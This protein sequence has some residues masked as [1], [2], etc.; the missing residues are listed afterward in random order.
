MPS[1]DPYR[2]PPWTFLYKLKLL[3]IWTAYHRSFKQLRINWMWTWKWCIGRK[4]SKTIIYREDFVRYCEI[5]G[6]KWVS[7]QN[8]EIWQVYDCCVIV[9][10]CDWS[11]TQIFHVFCI[12]F[13]FIYGNFNVLSFPL[14]IYYSFE[15]FLILV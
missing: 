7:R 4:L 6:K 13:K 15:S 1:T 5:R 9:I 2:T 14:S 12:L 10:V 11:Y 8:R 3:F